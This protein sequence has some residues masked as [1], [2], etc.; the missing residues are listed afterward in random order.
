MNIIITLIVI[1]VLFIVGERI[2]TDE[3][4]KAKEA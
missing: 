2:P 4:R 3:E 1:G